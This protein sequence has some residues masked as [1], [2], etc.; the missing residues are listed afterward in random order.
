MKFN[1]NEFEEFEF[2]QCKS[3]MSINDIYI[4]K[5]VVSKKFPFGKQV[6]NISLVR[7][8]LYTCTQH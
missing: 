6:L 8:I 7:K 5:I 3:P 2:C 1:D 4:N